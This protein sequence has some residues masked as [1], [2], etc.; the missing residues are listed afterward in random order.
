[1]WSIFSHAWVITTN[2]SIGWSRSISWSRASWSPNAWY[3]WVVSD[4]VGLSCIIHL[5]EFIEVWHNWVALHR[6]HRFTLRHWVTWTRNNNRCTVWHNRPI[7]LDDWWLYYAFSVWLLRL[8]SQESWQSWL[9][10]QR[11][12]RSNVVAL[13]QLRWFVACTSVSYLCLS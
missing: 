1:M 6:S 2:V 9:R 8:S 4:W 11:H 12:I 13:A 5:F 3:L 10:W 7:V